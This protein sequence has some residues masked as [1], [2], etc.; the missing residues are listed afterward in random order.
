MNYQP[1]DDRILIK[2]DPQE[3]TRSGF[4]VA[5]ENR[6]KRLSGTVVAVGTGVPLHNLKIN[7]TTDTNE[8]AVTML[9]EIVDLIKN[10]RPLKAKVGDRV[11]YGQF[12]GTRI[13]LDGQEYLML[14]ESDV[15]MKEID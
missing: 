13:P 6:L 4:L 10:G 9:K 14:R 7:I 12:A 8:Q 11:L 1:Y 5:E 15:F 3:E 2:P